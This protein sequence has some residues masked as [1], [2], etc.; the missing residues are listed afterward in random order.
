MLLNIMVFFIFL[1]KWTLWQLT[2]LEE[3]F[4]AWLVIFALLPDK[5]VQKRYTQV[6]IEAGQ[7]L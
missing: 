3:W 5:A 6:E 7:L 4:A 2:L 1:K